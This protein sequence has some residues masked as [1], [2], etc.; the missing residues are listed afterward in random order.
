MPQPLVSVLEIDRNGIYS[1]SISFWYLALFIPH[2]WDSFMLLLETIVYSFL[3]PSDGFLQW[4][5]M[6]YL[7]SSW[8]AIG[9]SG[10]GTL[11]MRL[12]WWL[13]NKSYCRVFL[14]LQG[15][16]LLSWWVRVYLIRN[17]KESLKVI[18]VFSVFQQHR[19]VKF[20]HSLS[21]VYHYAYF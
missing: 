21:N 19:R 8:H 15:M 11:G 13:L 9:V 6:F 18:S 12:L 10:L 20:L 16:E 2:T 5:I 17:C 14:F 7:F 4:Y 1:T 3:L